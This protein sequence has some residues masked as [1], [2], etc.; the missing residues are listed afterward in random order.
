[1]EIN[2]KID[3]SSKFEFVYSLLMLLFGFGVI[4]CFIASIGFMI[5]IFNFMFL[6]YFWP[7]LIGLWIGIFKKQEGGYETELKESDA[8]KLNHIID[9]ICKKTGQKRPHKIIVT[10]GTEVA[11]TGFFR[12]KIIVGMVALKFM[13]END[14]S[15]IL[16]HEYGHFANKDTLLG[17]LTYRIQHFIEVQKEINRQN[18]DI[19]FTLIIYLPTWLFFWLLSKYFLLISLWYGRRVEFRADNF[20]SKLVGEQA[21]SD[22]L[23]K[24]CIISDIFDSVVPEHVLHYLKE[25]KQI[26]NVYNYIKPLYSSENIKIGLNSV[27]SAKSSWW[28]THPSISERLEMMGVKKVDISF[29]INLKDILEN[30][31]KYEKEASELMTFKMDYWLRLMALAQQ[32][33]EVED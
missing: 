22:T 30:Q 13:S 15:A 26:L 11:V 32:G 28:S 16:S 24:Y 23:V 9:N 31:E 2:S 5:Y 18:L 27:L 4:A 8:K 20:A 1:M 19:S 14:L 7:I 29:E 6:F 12:K 17:Y 33:S 10:E 3:G 21:F 25:N